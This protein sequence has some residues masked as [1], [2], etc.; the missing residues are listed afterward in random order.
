VGLSAHLRCSTPF[1]HYE[2]RELNSFTALNG[3]SKMAQQ[4]KLVIT[5]CKP[6]WTHVFFGVV[7]VWAYCGLP[8]D[9]DRVSRRLGGHFKITTRGE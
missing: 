9:V 1:S 4:V 2:L 6:W 7:K 3:G 5:I 8:V